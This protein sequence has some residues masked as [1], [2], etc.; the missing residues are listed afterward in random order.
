LALRL[1]VDAELAQR[2]LA[3]VVAN[4]LRFAA[5]RASVELRHTDSTVEFI[6]AD[7]GPGVPPEQREAIFAPGFRGAPPTRTPDAQAG[8]G[9]GLALAR[10]LARA[11]GGD[12]VCDGGSAAAFVVSLPSA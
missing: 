12:V 9:L 1:G 2:V 3:P 5:Q 4:A 6:V 7:D 11:A 10:R 8:I